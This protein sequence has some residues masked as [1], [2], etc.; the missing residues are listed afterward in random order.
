MGCGDQIFMSLNANVDDW[1]KRE[2][3]LVEI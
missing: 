3:N 2:G 1:I